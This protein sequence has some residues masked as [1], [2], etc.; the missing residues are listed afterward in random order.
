MIGSFSFFFE[1]VCCSSKLLRG[2]L[3]GRNLVEVRVRLLWMFVALS[4]PGQAKT[5]NATATADNHRMY[6]WTECAKDPD[7]DDETNE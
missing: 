4:D 6:D 5:A 3:Q 2:G 7:G 1:P